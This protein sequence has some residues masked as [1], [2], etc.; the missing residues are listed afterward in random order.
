[1]KFERTINEVPV[2]AEVLTVEQTTQVAG[3]LSATVLRPTGC[4]GCTSGGFLAFQ[5]LVINVANPA[6]M[7][8]AV[9]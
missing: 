7:A 5:N 6:P 2:A 9:D 1:M 4:L 3:G 8:M